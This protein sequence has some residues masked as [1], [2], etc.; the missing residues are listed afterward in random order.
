MTYI[1]LTKDEMDGIYSRLSTLEREHQELTAAVAKVVADHAQPPITM[2][3]FKMAYEIAKGEIGQKEI[4]GAQHNPRIQEYLKTCGLN[5][6]DETAWCSAFVNWCVTKAGLKGTDSAAAR[7]WNDWGMQ[8]DAHDVREGDIAVLWRGS[9]NSWQ[10]HVGF[11]AKHYFVN[12]ELLGGNQSNQVCIQS[13]P[14]D[15]VLSFRRW[16]G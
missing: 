6:G 1:Q 13:Y 10:G 16:V 12:G 14:L 3:P 4:P 9:R 8:V 7:S 5:T 11:V 2:H 15:R